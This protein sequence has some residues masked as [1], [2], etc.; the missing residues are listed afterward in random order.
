MNFQ[1][2]VRPVLCPAVNSPWHCILPRLP[3]IPQKHSAPRKSCS[4]LPRIIPCVTRRHEQA[5]NSDSCSVTT[6]FHPQRTDHHAAV[7]TVKYSSHHC[8]SKRAHRESKDGREFMVEDRCLGECAAPQT[9]RTASRSAG[10]PR[11]R[12]RKERTV[13]RQV[14]ACLY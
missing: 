14:C 5:P 11:E 10:V 3:L 8:T 12:K 9:K 6:H 2:A 7:K 13:Q 4:T 1:R